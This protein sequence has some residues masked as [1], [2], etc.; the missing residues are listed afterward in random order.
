MTLSTLSIEP[1]GLPKRL[2]LWSSSTSSIARSSAGVC[3]S[4]LTSSSSSMLVCGC[5][6]VAVCG[7][8]GCVD[9]L[10][11]REERGWRTYEGGRGSPAL[12]FPLSREKLS[13]DC[14]PLPLEGRRIDALG[15]SRSRI[16]ASSRAV[17]C[18]AMVMSTVGLDDLRS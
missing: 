13:V 10:I 6:T 8:C 15:M 16:E 5:A 17:S 3:W 11:V 1:L 12:C 9:D 14:L 18:S 4:S 2:S 7:I